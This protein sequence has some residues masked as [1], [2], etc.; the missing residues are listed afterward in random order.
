MAGRGTLY[1]GTSGFSYP[2]WAPTFYEPG[3][4][5][6]ALLRSYAERLSSVELNNT[7]YQHPTQPKIDAWLAATP[8]AF[9]FTVKA[10]KG[11]SIRAMRADPG[12][13][14]PWL[15]AP[16][17]WF[18]ERLGSVLFRV[19]DPVQRDD[20]A[21]RAF[22]GAWPAGMPLTLEFQHP[23]WQVD[24]IHMLLREHD[25]ALCAT[26]LDDLPQPDLRLTGPFL[27]VRLRRETYTDA[28]LEAWA[29]RIEPFLADGRDAYVFLR[30]DET[31]DSALR[32][33]ALG[34]RIGAAKAARAAAR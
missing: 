28:E 4:K 7:F 24:E 5:G 21:L 8:P 18:G 14:V 33:E 12:M 3:T 15:T 30:H 17:R 22:L 27:Y 25:A 11:G 32:A 2:R 29:R 6:D 9:R 19:P 23:S 1:V 16:Y 13:T 31:G 34:R 26:D 10:Q 20:D